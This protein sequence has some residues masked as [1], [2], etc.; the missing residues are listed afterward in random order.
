MM[1][2]HKIVLYL[3]LNNYLNYRFPNSIFSLKEIFTTFFSVLLKLWFFG[4]ISSG[5][6]LVQFLHINFPQ[7]NH[8]CIS[9][10]FLIYCNYYYFILYSK[11]TWSWLW[12]NFNWLWF[13]IF[14]SFNCWTKL[15]SLNNIIR[16]FQC[17]SNWTWWILSTKLSVFSTGWFKGSHEQL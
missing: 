16:G 11:I 4:L 14:D 2:V 7:L 1:I 8:I 13:N 15:C 17:Y 3:K 6:L 5:S 9:I 12:F 10:W